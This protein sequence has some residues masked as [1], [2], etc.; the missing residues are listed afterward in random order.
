MNSLRKIEPIRLSLCSE[1]FDHP[2]WI[3][4]LK[5]D[6]F[7]ALAYIADGKWQLVS[8]RRNFYKRFGSLCD[9]MAGLKVE[10]AI[11]TARLSA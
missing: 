3:F 8:R 4:E 9:A 6:G 7:R 1:P 10:S 5:H 11:H 2:D